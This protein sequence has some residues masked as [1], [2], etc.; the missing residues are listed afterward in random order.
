MTRFQTAAVS[1]R[2]RVFA[3]LEAQGVP[4]SEADDLVAALKAGAVAE[5][6]CQVVELDSM[7]PCP[8]GPEFEDG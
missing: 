8:R 4:A 2:L 6:Q 1:A 3:L 5:A 7:A